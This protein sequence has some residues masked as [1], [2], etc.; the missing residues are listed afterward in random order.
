M[1][2]YGY[3]EVMRDFYVQI[4]DFISD[5]PNILKELNEKEVLF[6]FFEMEEAV[7]KK[8]FFDWFIFDYTSEA[9]GKNLLKYFLATAV[10]EG[11]KKE[12]YNSFINNRYSIFEI[13]ALRTGKEMMLWDLLDEKEYHAK[14][15]S[16]TKE[17]QKG[18]CCLL[19]LLPFQGDY[20]LTGMGFAFPLEIVPFIKLSLRDLK[21]VKKK[22]VLTP[23]TMY[24]IFFQPEKREA[25]PI[26]ER[27]VLLCQ[28]AGLEKEYIETIIT[29]I[30]EEATQKGTY[31]NILSEAFRRIRPQ[32]HFKPEEFI[33]V[34]MDLWNSFI[35]EDKGFYERGPL[36]IALVSL[37]LSYVQARCDPKKFSDVKMAEEKAEKLQEE[38]FK[39][40]RE[41]LDGKTPEEAILEERRKLGN[42]QKE[43]KFRINIT[44][45]QPGADIEKQTQELFQ[46]EIKL[47]K[48]H[49][50][51]EAIEIYKKH[52]Q[53]HPQNYV[54]WQNMGIAYIQLLDKQNALRCFQKALKIKPDYQIAKNNLNFLLSATDEDLK[55]MAGQD[56]VKW[57]NEG[58]EI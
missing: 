19:R 17:V 34:F 50:P 23:L 27:F 29:R 18:Q 8:L 39:T 28:E 32:K 44:E 35:S 31:D 42:P 53:L 38:W 30:K 43:V 55:R 25:L 11:E 49:K 37:C 16:F 9:L 13:K 3:Q 26:R 45:L 21:R 52:L 4:S 51:L 12:I 36:E 46:Q 15:T 57:M 22:I 5:N 10:L 20:I 33:S 54:V 41:E 2:E 6:S 47:M 24:E 40:S 48:E 7:R 58:K 14:D 56:R 1:A